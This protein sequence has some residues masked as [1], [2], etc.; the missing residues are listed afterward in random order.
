MVGKQPRYLIQSE[1]L[2][3]LAFSAGAWRL[4]ARDD[5]LGW[6]DAT[7]APHLPGIIQ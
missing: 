1:Q 3:A 5:D 2:G 6:D 7:R 4:G